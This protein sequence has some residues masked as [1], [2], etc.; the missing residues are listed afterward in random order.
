MN[1]NGVSYEKIGQFYDAVMGDRTETATFIHDLIV[2][3][4][5]E[6]KTL[7]ELACG[8]GGILQLLARSYE[9]TGL[10]ASPR[11]LAIAR[12]KLPHVRL[13]RK[14]MVGFDLRRKF[15]VIICVFDSITHVL[16]FADWKRIFRTA[17]LHLKNDGLFL[18]DINTIAKLQRRIRTPQCVT[19]FG[20]NSLI[21]KVTD[22][23]GGIANWN[24]RV[25]ESRG[26]GRYR[27]FQEDI[28]ETSFPVAKIKAA[29]RHRFSRIKVID[30]FGEK[31]GRGSDRLYFVC[32][33]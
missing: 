17:A 11:M 29:L 8:T 3:H 4:K 2:E 32:Q 13:L 22:C 23:G 18:F 28:A 31:P 14:N 6:A 24:I 15:D 25:F 26:L 1:A 30:P 9:V 19:R 20:N 33:R 21:M 10:D 5:P 12:R 27:I 16:R 7:L